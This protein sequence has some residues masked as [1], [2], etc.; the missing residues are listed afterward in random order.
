M[1]Q[2]KFNTAP[3]RLA[4]GTFAASVRDGRGMGAPGAADFRLGS[5]FFNKAKSAVAVPRE[6]EV[7][8]PSSS[9][10]IDG[11][12]VVC[13]PVPPPSDRELARGFSGKDYEC[14][15]ALTSLS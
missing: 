7:P 8:G 12:A 5:R 11:E 13:D 4:V 6:R 3:P 2:L 14:R 1:R 10:S 15:I 9:I